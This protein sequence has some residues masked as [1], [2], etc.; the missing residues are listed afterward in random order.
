MSKNFYNI[1]NIDKRATDKEIK[2]A[3]RL[4]CKKYHPDK[5]QNDE[6]SE[7]K[8][9]EVVTAYEVLIDK[10]KKSRYDSMGHESYVNGGQHQQQHGDISDLFN[11]MQNRNEI[12]RNK[13]RYSQEHIVSLTMDEVFLGINKTI[14]YSSLEKCND[15]DGKGGKEVIICN[16]CDGNGIRYI[17][18]TTH[19]G[20]IQQSIECKSCD[21]RG[22]KIPNPCKSCMGYGFKSIIKNENIN[23]PKSVNP[24][25]RIKVVNGG[26]YYRE[27]GVDKY[28]DLFLGF[29]I[30]QKKFKFLSEMDLISELEIDYPTLIL[31]GEVEFTSIDGSK[32]KLPISKNTTIGR[33]LKLKGRGLKNYNNE[34]IRGDQYI[35]VNLKMPT[36]ITKEEENLLNK[37]KKYN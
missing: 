14:K 9:K 7:K 20:K 13:N 17:V 2:K 26:N 29:D 31:G 35:R 34:S 12:I 16:D 11:E 27:K 23:L 28:G 8:F 24:N 19:F 6:E 37:L 30:V 18:Q 5:T 4:L 3:Y 33:K 25:F 15:C 36:T 21:G 1:L 10:N 32:L 22:F